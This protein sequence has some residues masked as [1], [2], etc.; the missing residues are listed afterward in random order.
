MNL[1]HIIDTHPDDRVAIIS[2]GRPTTYGALREQIAHVRGGGEMGRT[3]YE[4]GRLETKANTF[5]DFV[6]CAEHLVAERYT[7]AARLGAR[8]GSAGGL[9][10]GAVANLRPEL[11]AAIVA[12]GG[13]TA[14]T[15]VVPAGSVSVIV[16]PVASLGPLFLSVIE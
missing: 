4:Q 14:E 15:K 6:A 11:F 12:P 2:R 13:R 16:V 8:G 3:W 7:T 10:M 9:L 1:A 5:T